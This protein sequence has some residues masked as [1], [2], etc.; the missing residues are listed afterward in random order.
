[1]SI[2][3]TLNQRRSYRAFLDTP[4]EQSLLE[5]V[6][7]AAMRAPSNSNIQPW[8]VYL[9]TGARLKRLKEATKARSAAAP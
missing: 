5:D 3:E 8:H 4:V 7:T 9:V 6:L 1:M 2:R